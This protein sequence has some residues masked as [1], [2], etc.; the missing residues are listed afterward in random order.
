MDEDDTAKEAPVSVA[1][2]DE[3]L[4]E[5]LFAENES[6]Y[7]QALADLETWYNEALEE[8][9]EKNDNSYDK[10]MEHNCLLLIGRRLTDAWTSDISDEVWSERIKEMSQTMGSGSS[11][12]SH[13][14]AIF[15]LL[16][17]VQQAPLASL[18]LGLLKDD[19]FYASHEMEGEDYYGQAIALM[20]RFA[21]NESVQDGALIFLAQHVSLSTWVGGAILSQAEDAFEIIRRAAVRY[22]Q[23]DRRQQAFDIFVTSSGVESR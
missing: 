4:V 22:P 7:Q 11:F 9:F 13:L 2:I 16:R 6:V 21:E 20:K 23:S 18:L 12:G 14:W 17:N 15:R 10:L 3:D 5:R 1:T 19:F 8:A